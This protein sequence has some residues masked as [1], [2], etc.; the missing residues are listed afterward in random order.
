MSEKTFA[1]G[2]RV[3]M[4]GDSITQSGFG[5]AYIQ[6]YY[7]TH[8]PERRV[9]VYNLGISGDNAYGATLDARFAEIF[10]VRPTEVVV[11][12]G[13]NDMNSRAY[14]SPA[15][16]PEMLEARAVARRR[17]LDAM[18]CLV[19]ML[20]ERGLPVTLCSAVGRNEHTEAEEGFRTYGANDALY[21]MY[22]DNLA[23]IG[24]GN[25]KNT[26]DYLS[27]IQALQAEICAMGGPSLYEGDRTHLSVL[28]QAMMARVLLASQG[29]PVTLPSAAALAAGWREKP[30]SQALRERH[31]IE[32]RWRDLAWVYPGR[33]ES[34]RGLTLDAGIEFWRREALREDLP[35][36]YPKLYRHYV[37][38]AKNEEAILGDYLAKTDALYE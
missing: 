38:N 3:A 2:A 10:A 21:A 16:T 14:G 24:E 4:V 34:T 15:P 5:V 26:V 28:G 18:V 13:A 17:H 20:R 9:K 35:A 12:F 22:R 30:L 23:A 36:Y 25:L 7:L 1:G 8:L 29:L 19:G 11:M 27:P 32:H 37:E 6:D 31:A 33:A